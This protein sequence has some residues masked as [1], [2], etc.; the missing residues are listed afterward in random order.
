[1]QFSAILEYIFGSFLPKRPSRSAQNHPINKP[2]RSVST[3]EA[4]DRD[5]S[6]R[7]AGQGPKKLPPSHDSTGRR[8]GR[9]SS[10]RKERSGDGIVRTSASPYRGSTVRNIELRSSRPD[11]SAQLRQQFSG[12][13]LLP[14][15]QIRSQDGAPAGA[16]GYR[17]RS[18]I[19]DR[20]AERRRRR[21]FAAAGPSRTGANPDPGAAAAEVG[22]R[23]VGA[24][25]S[26]S[27]HAGEGGRAQRQDHR[28]PLRPLGSAEPGGR[29]RN[30]SG[31]RRSGSFISRRI[32]ARHRKSRD[33]GPD[34][35]QAGTAG[36]GRVEDD[37]HASGAWGRDL[38]AVALDRT[39]AAD[40]SQPP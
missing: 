24:D 18:G 6:H 21:F 15:N 38:Q 17:W 40:H 14:Q 25:G 33:P 7:R 2:A 29:S 8:P 28:Q 31:G 3:N 37:A 16:G 34:P 35:V 27:V 26:D 9:E 20:G 22:D 36:R 4:H 12:A 23:P 32:P 1:L 11:N 5:D 19:P 30:R 13:G 10:L 39:R